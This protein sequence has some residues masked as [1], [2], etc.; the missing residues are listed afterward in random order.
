MKYIVE[1][2]IKYFKRLNDSMYGKNSSF[3]DEQGLFS[4]H[5]DEYYSLDNL[6]KYYSEEDA[7]KIIEAKIKEKSHHKHIKELMHNMQINI[8]DKD[9]VKFK[10]NQDEFFKN[11]T[12][13]RIAEMYI[14]DF[15]SYFCKK[16]LL[17]YVDYDALSY[18][19]FK[20]LET[21]VPIS[22]SSGVEIKIQELID[23]YNGYGVDFSK[24]PR[25]EKVEKMFKDRE[26]L[27]KKIE[28]LKNEEI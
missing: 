24:V 26:K 8:C 10:E 17:D 11:M 14:D 18:I 9:F 12:T 16:E 1:E 7:I 28:M 4:K 3:K 27:A 6:K 25:L 19:D 23:E 13:L 5:E 20:L 21:I 22:S 2:S 15:K